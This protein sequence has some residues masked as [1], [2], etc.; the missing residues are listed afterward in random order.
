MVN[1]ESDRLAALLSGLDVGEVPQSVPNGGLFP[2]LLVNPDNSG[3]KLLGCGDLG[4]AVMEL[5]PFFCSPCCG[6]QLLASAS[7]LGCL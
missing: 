3:L 7:L 2:E 5:C 6:V 4:F 1:F